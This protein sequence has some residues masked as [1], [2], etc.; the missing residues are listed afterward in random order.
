MQR[1]VAQRV[2]RPVD[3]ALDC[4]TC[5]E[6]GGGGGG[7]MCMDDASTDI[8]EL[9]ILGRARSSGE[10]LNIGAFGEACDGR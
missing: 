3:P 4:D 6:E 9:K 10:S 5:R 8:I 7:G 2:C 1:F